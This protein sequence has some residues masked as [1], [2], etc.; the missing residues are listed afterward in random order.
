MIDVG[1][2]EPMSSPPRASDQYDI[3]VQSISRGKQ[4]FRSALAVVGGLLSWGPTSVTLTEIAIRDRSAGD[5]IVGTIKVGSNERFDAVL[6]RV[7]A[8]AE[9]MSAAEF[10]AAWGLGPAV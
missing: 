5:A 3:A 10:R 6:D 7:R 4:A 8:D 2:A 1:D 9:E